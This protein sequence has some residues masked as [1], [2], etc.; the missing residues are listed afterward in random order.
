V[1]TYVSSRP[2][3]VCLAATAQSSAPLPQNGTATADWVRHADLG[4]S[5]TDRHHLKDCLHWRIVTNDTIRLF[6]WTQ[7]PSD[8]FALS[9]HGVAKVSACWMRVCQMRAC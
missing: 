2:L 5:V 3:R 4:I 7:A 6:N 8:L 1:V 9:W